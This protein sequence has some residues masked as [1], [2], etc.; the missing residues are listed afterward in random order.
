MRGTIT[1]VSWWGELRRAAEVFIEQHVSLDTIN[2][3]LCVFLPAVCAATPGAEVPLVITLQANAE[4]DGGKVL[5]DNTGLIGIEGAESASGYSY[6]FRVDS[7]ALV[8][9]P[10][11]AVLL[12][13]GVAVLWAGARRKWSTRIS[14]CLS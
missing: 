14:P 6:P 11:T 7:P 10:G 12:L 13:G 9:E 5:A 8:P 3:V 1:A 2:P 4:G